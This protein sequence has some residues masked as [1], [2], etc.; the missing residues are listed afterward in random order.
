MV[1]RTDDCR[2]DEPYLAAY[3]YVSPGT[4]E[5]RLVD[6][7]GRDF[8][9]AAYACCQQGNET[10]RS[11]MRNGTLPKYAAASTT[12]SKARSS[13]PPST[14]APATTDL[15]GATPPFPCL[16]RCL[17]SCV[18]SG[19]TSSKQCSEMCAMAMTTSREGAQ[20]SHSDAYQWRLNSTPV[21]IP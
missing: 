17:G 1:Y 3:E 21:L 10:C 15:A 4:A 2:L 14:T 7:I 12:T 20:S 19:L 11:N 5:I 16:D 8:L 18:Q 13:V 9:P 6:H